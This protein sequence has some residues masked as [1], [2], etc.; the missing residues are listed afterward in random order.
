MRFHAILGVLASSCLL[1]SACG[2]DGPNTACGASGQTCCANDTCNSG[3]SCSSSTC[4]A[5]TACGDSGQAC[6]ANDSCNA[7]LSCSDGACQASASCGASGQACCSGS[8]CNAGLTCSGGKCQA[9]ASCGASGQACCIGSTCNAGLACSGGKCQTPTSSYSCCIND[10]FYGCA[11]K[12]AFD[13][14]AG[15]DASACHTGCSFSD[16]QCN[17]DCD[18]KAMS[19]KHDPSKCVRNDARNGECTISPSGDCTLAQDKCSYDQDC[20]SGKS[21]NSSTGRCFETTD[22]CVGTPCTYNQ[23]CSD[24]EGCSSGTGKCFERSKSQKGLACKYNQDC[25]DNASCNSA[26]GK[27]N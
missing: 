5:S 17:I 20:G 21:C 2:G 16:I 7:G 23:D 10:V 3:L 11:D 12:A 19:S 9:S 6:C 4:Q 14:C 15:F 26:T 18:N 13:L 1:L 24:G 8:T 22:D 27:C 25:S